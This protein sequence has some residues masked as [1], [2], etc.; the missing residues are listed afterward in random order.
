MEK[1]SSQD[2]LNTSLTKH[3]VEGAKEIELNTYN[4]KDLEAET[5]PKSYTGIKKFF[6]S[7]TLKDSRAFKKAK[8]A[9]SVF[10]KIQIFPLFKYTELSKISM[11]Y[12]FYFELYKIVIDILSLLMIFIGFESY[13]LKL[14]FGKNDLKTF[15]LE[16]LF[17]ITKVPIVG[18]VSYFF[19]NAFLIRKLRTRRE[20][21][22]V[23]DSTLYM[24][25]W[26]EDKFSLLF[27]N[28]PKDVSKEEL[29][30]TINNK[31][32][33]LK[34]EG[35]VQEIIFLQDCEAYVKAKQKLKAVIDK[36][37]AKGHL[38]LDMV[39]EGNKTK[40]IVKREDIEARIKQLEDQARKYKFYHGKAIII[41]E[42]VSARNAAYQFYREPSLIRSLLF[43]LKKPQNYIRNQL[44]YCTPA[45]EPKDI[46]Y[47]NLHYSERD[48][49]SRNFVAWGFSGIFIGLGLVLAYIIIGISF[50]VDNAETKEVLPAACTSHEEM[51]RDTG[52]VSW[53]KL[54]PY[55]GSIMTLIIGG[56]L[57]RIYKAFNN[58]RIH[59]SESS[60]QASYINYIIII[61]FFNYVVVFMF[62]LLNFGAEA[63]L[64]Q[65]FIT[66]NFYF[67]KRG[68]F[69]KIIRV[70]WRRKYL[71]DQLEKDANMPNQLSESEIKKLYKKAN[72]DFMAGLN[73]LLPIIFIVIAFFPFHPFSILPVGMAILYGLAWFDKYVI[74]K[75]TKPFK[76][77]SYDY[78]MNFHKVLAWDYS[79]YFL[80][81]IIFQ[82]SFGVK[83]LEL[84]VWEIVVALTKG[85]LYTISTIAP[86]IIW[87]SSF[88]FGR[89][90]L[91]D[92]IKMKFDKEN[93]HV[94]YETVCSQFENTYKKEY[95]FGSV[96]I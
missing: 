2:L 71:R 8:Q 1:K 9:E 31:L 66:L 27:E 17:Y 61:T 73:E 24:H 91:G 84:E 3:L 62:P 54:L 37:E 59:R 39:F 38:D 5:R 19:L 94:K 52:V 68:V 12:H 92:K 95:P 10:S 32:V 65:V 56:I 76:L 49:F 35:K 42:T 20:K 11:T 70:D 41:F 29:K 55:F 67:L 77:K 86:L 48:R 93:A 26:S 60:K 57:E 36:L 85:D 53:L 82:Y 34:E 81:L 18:M 87:L 47:E 22:M 51:L 30:I 96:A 89:S 33:E 14:F 80:P 69:N 13:F 16:D 75:Y 40:H 88:F 25:S 72:F 7:K 4:T 74:L 23:N 50:C 64:G 15:S 90:D 45:P 28:I 6:R 44:V 78:G 43:K 21:E 63:M 46:F 79:V 58:F 83:N